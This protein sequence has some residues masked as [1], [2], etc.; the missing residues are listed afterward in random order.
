MKKNIGNL[1]SLRR[2]SA[3]WAALLRP[4]DKVALNGPLASGKTTFARCII[5]LLARRWKAEIPKEITSP[6]FNLVHVY[7]LKKIE[8]WHFD[9][10]R[11]NKAEEIFE[12]GYEEAGK[13]AICLIEW[14]QKMERWLPARRLDLTFS[15]DHMG[16]DHVGGDPMGNDPI[17]GDHPP[18][19][20]KGDAYHVVVD[21]RREKDKPW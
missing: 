12:L 1:S 9:L 3:H 8:I 11:I 19:V 13:D 10:Y 14:A 4:G 6:T 20:A 7:D 15:C 2:F 18:A 16:G 5:P 21:D 17:G